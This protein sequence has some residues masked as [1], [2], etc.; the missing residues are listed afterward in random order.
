MSWDDIS[1][2][3]KAA[4]Y[5]RMKGTKGHQWAQRKA[6]R[7]AVARLVEFGYSYGRAERAVREY[8]EAARGTQLGPDWPGWLGMVEAVGLVNPGHV[9][10][11]AAT[12]HGQQRGADTP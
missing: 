10:G 1:A 5:A 3:R 4:H 8:A 11:R 7:D 2:K 12:L 6:R 9:S